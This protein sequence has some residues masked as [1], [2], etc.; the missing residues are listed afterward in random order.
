MKYKVCTN[1]GAENDA[2]SSLCSSCG[3]VLP[4]AI[5]APKNKRIDIETE[6]ESN[7][8]YISIK[9][10]D[11]I[12]AE[13]RPN[14]KIYKHLMKQS[15]ASLAISTPFSVL[16]PLLNGGF[17]GLYGPLIIVTV[18]IIVFYVATL[19]ITYFRLKKNLWGFFAVRYLI[20]QNRVVVFV[21]KNGKLL[22]NV[23]PINEISGALISQKGLT[24]YGL[25][26]V[27]LK[28]R[29]FDRDSRKMQ[30]KSIPIIDEALAVEPDNYEISKKKLKI[31]SVR[32]RSRF[33]GRQ[34]KYLNLEDAQNA[35]RQIDSLILENSKKSRV[36][37]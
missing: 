34:L 26:N 16:L 5:K 9:K 11:K 35:K 4:D 3:F 24:K 25:A 21:F 18:I 12:I 1:C 23:T 6:I 13:Y 22:D 30:K 8:A 31:K 28:T 20:T 36:R 32:K 7:A 27:I 37:I 10:Y 17:S 29:L 15:M 14:P 2:N 19:P 33:L